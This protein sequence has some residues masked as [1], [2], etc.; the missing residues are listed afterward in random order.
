MDASTKS[1]LQGINNQKAQEELTKWQA[2]LEQIKTQ[3]AN[4]TFEEQ[5][6]LVQTQLQ[7]FKQMLRS[8]TV[9]ANVDEKTEDTMI[10]NATAEL[11]KTRVEAALLRS[12]INVNTQEVKN[13]K[14]EINKWT[15]EL[16][17]GYLRIANEKRN[18][19]SE[20]ANAVT[21][22]LKMKVEEKMKEWEQS[23]PTWDKAVTG[24]IS[25]LGEVID[26]I[27]KSMPRFY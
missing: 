21:N 20:Q 23:H 3:L 6:Q 11:V 7:Q 14:A 18:S 16:T 15:V 1:I 5:T 13:M 24:S 9:R 8:A 12:E 2:S 19:Y 17:Q 26:N 27:F 25:G 4:A 10:Q 22:Y